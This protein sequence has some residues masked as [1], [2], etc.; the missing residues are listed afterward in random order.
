M[1]RGMR[2]ILTVI[3]WA[4][5]AA[6]AVL[7]LGFASSLLSGGQGG[8]E[9]AQAMAYLLGALAPPAA[10]VAIYIVVTRKLRSLRSAESASQPSSSPA[11]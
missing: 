11:P 2:V 1:L 10:L 4:C 9:L 7:V 3:R 8:R 6:L 5:V